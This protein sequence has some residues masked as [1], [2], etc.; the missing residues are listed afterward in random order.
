MLLMRFFQTVR[1]LDLRCLS[2]QSGVELS[3][4]R[5]EFTKHLD[6]LEGQFG[7]PVSDKVLVASLHRCGRAELAVESGGDGVGGPEGRPRLGRQSRHA[8]LH[9]LGNRGFHNLDDFTRS[10]I[11]TKTY[12]LT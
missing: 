2:R 7:L 10:N 1:I 11:F 9:F 3:T 6:N 8:W 5:K 4:H 12:S